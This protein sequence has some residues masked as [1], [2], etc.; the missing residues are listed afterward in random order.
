MER[1]PDLSFVITGFNALST[2]REAVGSALNQEHVRVEVVYVD[3][4]S[5]DG[6]VDALASIDDERFAV[7][8]LDHLGRARA[9][10]EGIGAT[11]GD[12]VAILD[13]DDIALPLRSVIQL[14]F[15]AAN[16]GCMAV[17]GQLEPFDSTGR[18]DRS[19]RL[20]FPTVPEEIDAWIKRGR[21]PLAH[22]ALTF[23]RDW[24][25]RIGGYDSSVLRAEDF[26]LVLRGWH[27]A[28][29]AAVPQIVTR[30][31]TPLFPTW[32]Y[33]RRELDYTRAVH[34]R[35]L[36]RDTEPLRVERRWRDFGDDC[37]KWT[38]QLF[39]HWLQNRERLAV[40]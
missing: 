15:F 32:R 36:R 5:T 31:R 27:P 3:D 25:E 28:T 35:W 12:F 11:H 30:Y 1:Q 29:Y 40:K 16:Q 6:S 8:S 10:N 39:R 23:R 33:W 13:A 7:V 22:P 2:V 18:V 4:G 37:L 21:M 20:R 26:D 17:G 34:R 19:S 24:F 38:S 9:L 14:A